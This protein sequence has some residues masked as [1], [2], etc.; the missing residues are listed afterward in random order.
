MAVE[1]LD[2]R[3]FV[4]GAAA[5]GGGLALGGPI[6]ALGADAASGRVRR[7]VGYGPLRDA[8]EES[9]GEV[10]L[11]LPKGFKYRVISRDYES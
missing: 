7:V 2:R 8:R 4:K 3:T 10:Y 11:Q 9:T 1:E 6:A 5:V